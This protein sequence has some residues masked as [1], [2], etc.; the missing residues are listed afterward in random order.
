MALSFSRR[1]RASKAVERRQSRDTRDERLGRLRRP[2]ALARRERPPAMAD[3]E[4][5]VYELCTELH[6]K[7]CISDTTWAR[8]IALF[9]EHGVMDLIGITATTHCWR[10]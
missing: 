8:A 7:R 10:W 2:S 9:G 5:A 3:D 6:R 1:R 4:A